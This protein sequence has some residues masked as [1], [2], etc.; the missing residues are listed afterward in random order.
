MMAFNR[1]LCEIAYRDH[2]VG[3]PR[4]EP[5]D[6][7]DLRMREET[8]SILF[9]AMHMHDERFSRSLRERDPCGKGHP[10]M[11]VNN[12]ERFARELGDNLERESLNLLKEVVTVTL[13]RRV[14]SRWR[15]FRIIKG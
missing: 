2:F 8:T 6:L 13:M 9:K 15:R 7:R 14:L 10:V 12:V 4:T 3:V 1:A 11:C 5:L